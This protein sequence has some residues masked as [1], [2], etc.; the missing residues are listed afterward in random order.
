MQV[1]AGSIYGWSFFWKRSAKANLSSKYRRRYVLLS[2]ISFSSLMIPRPPTNGSW[3]RSYSSGQTGQTNSN[4]NKTF[5]AAVQ[6]LI[7]F[8]KILLNFQTHQWTS[9]S[10]F[11]RWQ[12]G[13]CHTWTYKAGQVWSAGL[14]LIIGNISLFRSYYSL[15]QTWPSVQCQ[16]LRPKQFITRHVLWTNPSVS[17]EVQRS[18]KIKMWSEVMMNSPPF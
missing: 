18:K 7:C 3:C 12:L 2:G 10:P 5:G 1:A 17:L 8:E 6:S 13:A 15:E 9:A 16:M 4:Y 14:P 11:F